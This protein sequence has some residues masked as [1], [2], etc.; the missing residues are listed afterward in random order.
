[1]VGRLRTYKDSVYDFVPSPLYA[2]GIA[3]GLPIPLTTT[4]ILYN[5]KIEKATVDIQKIGDIQ[6]NY[7]NTG[8]LRLCE[9]DPGPALIPSDFR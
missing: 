7:I 6:R 3:G 4:I 9:V 5:I 8:N 2:M 1:M